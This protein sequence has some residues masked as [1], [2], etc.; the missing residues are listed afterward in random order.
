[1]TQPRAATVERNVSRGCE[2]SFSKLVVY[3]IL[4][5][6]IVGVPLEAKACADD[7]GWRA[8]EGVVTITNPSAPDSCDA[9]STRCAFCTCCH[10]YATDPS[11]VSPTLIEPICAL[12]ADLQVGVLNR[13]R[14]AI[15]EPPRQ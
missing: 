13:T 1:M 9:D 11:A 10:G 7:C 4:S 8:T 15:E 5:F 6:L 2:R 14:A 12:N 3:L